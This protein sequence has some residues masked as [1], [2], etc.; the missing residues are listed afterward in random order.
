MNTGKGVDDIINKLNKA[1]IRKKNSNDKSIKII[2]LEDDEQ[3]LSK[4]GSTES[5]KS[6]SKSMSSIFPRM[7]SFEFMPKEKKEE[8]IIESNHSKV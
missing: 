1:Q 8:P 6:D 2:D 7:K 3:S 4:K 5:I